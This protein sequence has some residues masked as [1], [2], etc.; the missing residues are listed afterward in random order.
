M[1]TWL[2]WDTTLQ[3]VPVPV[4]ENGHHRL[5][6]CMRSGQPVDDMHIW[7][8]NRRITPNR[9]FFVGLVVYRC[10]GTGG[11]IRRDDWVCSGGGTIGATELSAT[12]LTL[13]VKLVQIFSHR[14]N[15]IVT[16][17]WLFRNT[18]IVQRIPRLSKDDDY[19]PLMKFCLIYG[20]CIVP[21]YKLCTG[22]FLQPRS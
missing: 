16:T 4:I 11:T 17:I 18:H 9:I 15:C 19:P 3:P 22:Y 20:V 8:R 7:S 21:L 1:L 14:T 5:I 13:R 6:T 2:A 12:A 10:T